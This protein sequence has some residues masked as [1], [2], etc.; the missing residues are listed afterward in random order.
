MDIPFD[1]KVM[2]MILSPDEKLL[3]ILL[4]NQV[5]QVF[6]VYTQDLFMTVKPTAFQ[7]Y[8][9]IT[10]LDRKNEYILAAGS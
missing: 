3:A 1:S 6:N 4:F 9:T 8:T 5:I 2:K 7:K 10:F